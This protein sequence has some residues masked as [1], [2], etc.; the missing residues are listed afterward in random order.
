MEFIEQ[1]NEPELTWNMTTRIATPTTRIK[2]E[3]G[4]SHMLAVHVS[5]VNC[6]TALRILPVVLWI[7][8]QR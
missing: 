3:L 6:N 1:V 7:S 2:L 8:L 4:S 5:G